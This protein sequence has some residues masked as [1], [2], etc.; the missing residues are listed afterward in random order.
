MQH[1]IPFQHTKEALTALDNGGH[2]YNL[3]T[4]A[5]DGI[6]TAPELGKVAGM[7]SSRQQMSVYLAMSVCKLN[8]VG[9]EQVIYSLSPEL[10]SA[11]EQH[12]PLFFSPALAVAEARV[13]SGAI[14]TGVP[15]RIDSST[16]FVG[17]VIVPIFV[18]GVTTMMM[19]PMMEQYDVYELYDEQSADQFIIAHTRGKEKLPETAI[20]VGGI[21]KE[22]KTDKSG[23]T[24]PAKFLEALYYSQ[25]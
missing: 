16:A 7:Y 5:N 20:R 19:I 18:G 9:Q 15:K 8:A 11:F 4:K 12:L 25:V 24:P 17:F 14:I 2:F 23:S 21:I 6:I 13:A 3:F 1:I 10:K 22:L